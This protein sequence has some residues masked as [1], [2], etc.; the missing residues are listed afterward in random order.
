MAKGVWGNGFGLERRALNHGDGRI[1]ADDVAYSKA[2][3]RHA[4]GVEEQSPG[5]SL[6][7]EA[8]P[9]VI[10]ERSDRFGPQRA[11]RAS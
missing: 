11:C 3:D 9:E 8:L 5:F 4:M 7:G 1:F 2:R 10:F 6:F